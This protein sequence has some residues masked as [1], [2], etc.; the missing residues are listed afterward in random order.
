M[1]RIKAHRRRGR[2]VDPHARRRHTT[3]RGR[4]GLPEIVDEGSPELVA[5]KRIAANGS[6]AAVELTDY[7]AILLAHHLIDVEQHMMLATVATWLDR[8]RRAREL[9]S[10]SVG[11]LWGAILS[12]QGGARKW[13]VPI[14][15]R[16][17]R[18][19]GDLAWFRVCQIRNGFAQ[20]RQLELL[21]IVM[22]VAAGE[23]MPH[24]RADLVQLHRGI[25]L[26]VEILRHARRSPRPRMAAE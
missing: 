13:S 19:A 21:D 25:A 24:N 6:G 4:K 11:G 7:P 23:V 5:R 15:D 12:G 1:A 8:I 2:P 9:S 3:R 26:V 22:R 14:T 16:R 20:L 18:T 10:T 17:S